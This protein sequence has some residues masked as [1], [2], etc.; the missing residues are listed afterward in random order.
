MLPYVVLARNVNTNSVALYSLLASLVAACFSSVLQSF[1]TLPS[2]FV[3]FPR[4]TLWSFCFSEAPDCVD[5]MHSRS[6]AY[7]FR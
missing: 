7:G 6:E 3:F 1:V 4:T 5:S 2:G